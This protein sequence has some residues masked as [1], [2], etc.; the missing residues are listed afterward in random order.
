MSSSSSSSS[1]L[2]F[3]LS[4]VLRPLS[5]P[6]SKTRLKSNLF[7]LFLFSLRS[8][9]APYLTIRTLIVKLGDGLQK[10]KGREGSWTDN[11]L[12]LIEFIIQIIMVWNIIEAIVSIQYPST[13][14]PPVRE[15]LVMTP[16][17]VTSP[18]TRSY[19][20]SSPSHNPSSP[21]Q[22]LQRSIY[23]PSSSSNNNAIMNNVGPQTPNRNQQ[24]PHPL[25]N[26]TANSSPISLTTAKILNLPPP[27]NHSPNKG[28]FFEKKDSQ[29]Q[30]QPS[31]SV[32]G[33]FV[34]IDREE[35]DWVDNV[36]KGV[37]GKS[38]KIGL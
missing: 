23:R 31:N 34:L 29:S 37:R 2:P 24:T 22:S 25:S 5:P 26:S 15:G 18:L 35:K 1:K 28:L 3:G 6:L 30:S 33:D 38:G 32:G 36:W 27:T 17:K 12:Y 21:S 7:V 13:Y 19:S 11:S 14:I 20:P 10:R 4:S 9:F 8:F 16:S